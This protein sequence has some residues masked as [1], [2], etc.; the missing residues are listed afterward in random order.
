ML[1]GSYAKCLIKTRQSFVCSCLDESDGLPS[2]RAGENLGRDLM[3]LNV[4]ACIRS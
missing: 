3:P 1:R 2:I 4:I